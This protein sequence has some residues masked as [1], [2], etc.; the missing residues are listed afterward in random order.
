MPGVY[1][2]FL[3]FGAVVMGLMTLAALVEHVREG[4]R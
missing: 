4:R 1:A 3:L 2:G